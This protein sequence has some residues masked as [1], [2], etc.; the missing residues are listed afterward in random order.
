MPTKD[1]VKEFLN[2]ERKIKKENSKN[3][4]KMSKTDL[5]N[6]VMKR[7]SLKNKDIKKYHKVEN[8]VRIIKKTRINEDGSKT[9]VTIYTDC[10]IDLNDFGLK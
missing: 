5:N 4:I 10:D 3:K 6:E 9:P 2:I 1:E 8:K 7:F